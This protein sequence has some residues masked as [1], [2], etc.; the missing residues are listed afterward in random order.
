MDHQKNEQMIK[1]N[2]GKEQKCKTQR[3][4][5]LYRKRRMEGYIYKGKNISK[6][7]IDKKKKE[8][9]FWIVVKIKKKK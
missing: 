9:K 5:I 6:R 8:V 4:R 7:R 3:I 1:K 2:E